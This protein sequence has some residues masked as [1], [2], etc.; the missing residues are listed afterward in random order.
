[1]T[2]PNENGF[3]VITEQGDL[4]LGLTPVN[5]QETKSVAQRNA[6]AGE[7]KSKTNDLY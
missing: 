4:G 2:Q 3:Y 7:D 5:E 1:M 6:D